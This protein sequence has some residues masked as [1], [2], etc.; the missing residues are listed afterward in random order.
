ME[1]NQLLK[2]VVDKG[3]SDLH[4]R[5]DSR[6]VLRIDG[7]LI[8]Q[9]DFPQVTSHEAER[10][11][12]QITT[13]EQRDTFLRDKELDFAYTLSRLARFRVNILSQRKTIRIACRMVSFKIP[14][15][16]EL[17]LPQICT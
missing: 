2:L 16:D 8:P 5:V 1:I 13:Q 17:D 12:E 3:A 7:K 15:I 11:F 6:P 14:T 10:L 9:D 4:L